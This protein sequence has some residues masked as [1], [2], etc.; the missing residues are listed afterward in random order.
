MVNVYYSEHFF[1]YI[2]EPQDL[3]YGKDFGNHMLKNPIIHTFGMTTGSTLV[4]ISSMV[5]L[6][7]GGLCRT[8][9]TLHLLR[10]LSSDVRW[11]FKI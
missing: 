9:P 11:C 7:R 1:I 2:M 5:Y 8:Y 6:L 10:L 3:R 4:F